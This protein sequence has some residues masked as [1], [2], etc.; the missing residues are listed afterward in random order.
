MHNSLHVFLSKNVL[1]ICEEQEIFLIWNFCLSIKPLRNWYGVLTSR[2]LFDGIVSDNFSILQGVRQGSVLSPW[3]FMILNDDLPQWSTN[4]MKDLCFGK[5]PC[6]PIMVADD[7]TLL[8][9]RVKGLQK[10]LNILESFTAW[11]GVSNSVQQKLLW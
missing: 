3:L 1:E 5:L 6:N 2:V 8:S 10:M 4:A 9:T 7:V 11:D